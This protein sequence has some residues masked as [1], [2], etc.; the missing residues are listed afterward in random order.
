MRKV[1]VSVL[2]VLIPALCFGAGQATSGVT[3]GGITDRVREILA[4]RTGSATTLFYTDTEIR[5]HANYAVFDIVSRSKC[6]QDTAVFTLAVTGVSTSG[7]TIYSGT[8]EYAWTGVSDYIT[9]ETAL[10]WNHKNNKYT[11]LVKTDI[12]SIGH[13]TDNGPPAYWYEWNDKI[14]IWPTTTQPYSG[15]SV[16]VYYTP[17]PEGL[18][19]SDSIVETPSN[20]DSAIIDYTV[21]QMLR[22]KKRYQE[23]ELYMKSYEARLDRYRSDLVDKPR[24]SIKDVKP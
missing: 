10:Y 19:A 12:K 15:Q 4:E 21:S 24:E 13:L 11:G 18:T 23:S 1:I 3:A 5:S 20:Y 2:L 17:M 9:I 7:G 22:K 8:T 14:G 6:I 16:Y